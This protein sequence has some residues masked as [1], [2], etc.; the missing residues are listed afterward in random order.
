MEKQKIDFKEDNNNEKKVTCLG[1]VFSNDNERR[2]LFADDEFMIEA[3][4]YELENNGYCFTY[5]HED[6]FQELGIKMDYGRI[7]NCFEIAK[8]RYLSQVIY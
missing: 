1:L 2:E 5:D 7:S 3:I 8:E 4:E 6:A